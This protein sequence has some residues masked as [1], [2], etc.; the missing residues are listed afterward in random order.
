MTLIPMSIY[1]NDDGRAKIE[2]ALGRDEAE[3]NVNILKTVIETGQSEAFERE[4][5]DLLR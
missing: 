2:L 5:L 3:E 1:F 4:R